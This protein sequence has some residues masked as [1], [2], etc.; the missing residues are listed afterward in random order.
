MMQ[1]MGQGGGDFNSILQMYV[2][3]VPYIKHVDILAKLLI[4]LSM[5]IYL[6]SSPC[7]RL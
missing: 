1:S 7:F 3:I 5:I 4:S 6:F 2:Y